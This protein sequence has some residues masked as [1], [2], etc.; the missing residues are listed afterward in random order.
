LAGR[1]ESAERDFQ[2]VLEVVDGVDENDRKKAQ[3]WWKLGQT[4]WNHNG[5]WSLAQSLPRI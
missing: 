2:A 4:L 3:V 5:K 1:H